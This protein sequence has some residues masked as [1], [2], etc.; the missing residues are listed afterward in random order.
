MQPVLTGLLDKEVIAARKQHGDNSF[1]LKEE[2][3]FGHYKRS[4]GL[5]STIVSLSLKFK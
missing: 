4:D 5:N 2:R 1:Q 3:T